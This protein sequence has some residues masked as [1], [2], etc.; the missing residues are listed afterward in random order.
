MGLRRGGER[1]GRG[2]GSVG[3]GGGGKSSDEGGGGGGGLSDG[4]GG[5]G[6]VDDGGG[7]GGGVEDG[8]GGGGSEGWGGWRSRFELEDVRVLGPEGAGC[9]IVEK[10]DDQPEEVFPLR[11]GAASGVER[12]ALKDGPGSRSEL[13]DF[14]KGKE[15][16]S[17]PYTKQ[18]MEKSSRCWRWPGHSI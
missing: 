5:G 17:E 9:A 15:I 3:G 14:V 12:A 7:G 6:G 4:G 1:G 13:R 8:G 2:G 16:L 18:R 10:L 11:F